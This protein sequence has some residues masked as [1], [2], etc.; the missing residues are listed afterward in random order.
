MP[1]RQARWFLG[2]ATGLGLCLAGCQQGGG[3]EDSALPSGTPSA[4]TLVAS[5]GFHAP[6]DAV[7][8]P[9]G[10]TF[11]FTAFTTDEEPRAGIFSVPS[12]GGEPELLFSGEPLEY[13]TG[14]LMSCDGDT[15]YVADMSLGDEL[16]EGEAEGG[17]IYT[18]TLGEDGL[19]VLEADGVSVPS[20]LAMGADCSTIHVTG[21]NHDGKPALFR[22]PA[23]GG[24]AAETHA[25]APL[26]SPTGVHVDDDDVAWV[27]DHLATGD[28]GPGS[29]FKVSLDGA[30]EEVVSG[31]RLGAPGGVSLAAGGVTA[32]IP[33][34]DAAGDARLVGIDTSTGERSELS[35]PQ[36]ISPAGIRTAREAGVFVVVDNEG[37]AI[38]RAE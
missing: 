28:D 17:T 7:A 11:Y 30:L 26:V 15:L 23:A 3:A 12:R 1:K 25:G 38:F 31:L 24:N 10:S 36:M 4:L 27:M 6:G 13:P 32:V 19:S 5:E 35:A 37:S 8:S 29:L 22:V 20:G 16:V 14:L 33:E 21:W 34:V 18:L 2:V 9:D